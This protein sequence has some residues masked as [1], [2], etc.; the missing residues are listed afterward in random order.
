MALQ[1]SVTVVFVF[2]FGFCSTFMSCESINGLR[3]MFVFGD[4]LLDPGNDEKLITLARADRPPYGRDLS[5]HRP[6]GRFCNGLLSSDILASLAGLPYP[7]AYLLEKDNIMSGTS[8]A[9]SGAGIMNLTG[10]QLLQRIDFFQQVVFFSDVRRQLAA[11][12]GAQQASVLVSRALFLVCLGNND[13]LTGYFGNPV[14]LSPMQRK[15]SPDQFRSLLISI[16]EQNL[17]ELYS[18]G[19]RKF[20]LV[21]LSAIGCIPLELLLT[22]SRDGRCNSVINDE[23]RRFNAALQA[24]SEKLQ[25][26]LSD[27]HFTYLNAFDVIYAIIENPVAHGFEYGSIACCGAG[28]Y[29]GVPCY[30][31]ISSVCENA[32]Q[33][34]FWDFAHPTQAINAVIANK[35]W[36]G[37]PP[38]VS[39]INVQQLAA[40]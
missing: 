4:S 2:C 6:T 11:R 20:A 16:F 17:L 10:Y 12:L 18:L 27:A 28:P 26:T 13:Y 21:S 31:A 23:V 37:S 39:P 9:S 32:S 8:F 30:Q 40:L 5:N 25:A 1:H 22:R 3:A 24:L 35:F 36:A 19:A 38:D 33:Y 7:P 29:R 14:G 34:V 15:Y